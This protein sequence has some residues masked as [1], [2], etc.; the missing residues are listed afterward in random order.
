[1]RPKWKASEGDAPA[2]SA[3]ARSRKPMTGIIIFD[4][5]LFRKPDEPG[6]F[7]GID[8]IGVLIAEP[9]LPGTGGR[10]TVQRSIRDAGLQCISSLPGDANG[11]DRHPVRL[12]ITSPAGGVGL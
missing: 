6:P 3:E 7:S 12:E 1:M 10:Q 5:I 11:R 2:D 4:V 9:G 8:F